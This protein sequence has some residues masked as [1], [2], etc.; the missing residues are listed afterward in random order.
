MSRM[1]NLDEKGITVDSLHNGHLGDRRKRP[2][3]SGLNKSQ[4]MNFLPK[5]W[6]L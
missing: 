6:P 3:W 4:C 5:K 2:L 1:T